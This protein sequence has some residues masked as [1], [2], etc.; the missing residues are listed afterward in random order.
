MWRMGISAPAASSLMLL[1]RRISS[2][3]ARR[4]LSVG[5]VA[6][7]SVEEPRES[8]GVLKIT[9]SWTCFT[10]FM[11]ILVYFLSANDLSPSP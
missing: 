9:H 3:V 2:T 11:L 1:A 6:R 5:S 7:P 10:C 4:H 8:S